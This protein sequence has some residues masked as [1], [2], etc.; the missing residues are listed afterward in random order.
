MVPDGARVCDV[1]TDHGYLPAALIKCGRVTSVVAT[2]IREKPLENARNNLAR[3]GVEN[4]RLLLCDGLSG[5]SR[6]DADTV[7]IAGMGAEVISGIL[8]RCDFVRDPSVLLLLQPMTSPELLRDC[9]AAQGFRVEREPTVE[10]TGRIYSVMQARF[11]G[12]LR[13][14]SPTERFAGLVTAHD[15]TGRRYL[16]KQYRR[17]TSCLEN[18]ADRPEEKDRFSLFSAAANGIRKRLEESHAL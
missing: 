8:E 4:V 3:L 10:D 15:E 6:V 14:L 17:L 18:L 16:E 1:G 9:L 7:I 5:V 11:D 12:V 13:E 2:D